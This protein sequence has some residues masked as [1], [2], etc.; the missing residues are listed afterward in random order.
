LQSYFRR[1]PGCDQ[2]AKALLITSTN[3]ATKLVKLRQTKLVSGFNDNRICTGHIDAN[4]DHRR[5]KED[6]DVPPTESIH[7]LAPHLFAQLSMNHSKAA[8]TE[9]ATRQI[10]EQT[11]NRLE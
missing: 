6:I 1:I 10:L 5:R 8:V 3:P 4:F 7:D 9:P 11:D 2:N